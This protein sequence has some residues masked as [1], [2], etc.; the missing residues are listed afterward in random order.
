VDSNDINFDNYGRDCRGICASNA[1]M[2]AFDEC[3]QCLLPSDTEFDNCCGGN[4]NKQSNV[5][6][7]CLW[8]NVT[9][10]EDRG[11]DCTGQC[12]G[13]YIIDACGQCLLPSDPS[14][15]ACTHCSN[16]QTRDCNDICG[17]NHGRNECGQCIDAAL[18]DFD[19]YGKDCEG[20][21]FHS[22]FND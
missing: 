6:G 1:E 4:K 21:L 17:G 13:L 5:C 14:F 22:V 10:F 9:D 2:Y 11:K 20:M 3:G 18:P 8:K 19:D 15:D 7:L 16:N 12:Y